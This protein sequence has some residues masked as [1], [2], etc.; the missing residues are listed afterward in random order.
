MVISYIYHCIEPIFV[1]LTIVYLV[2][3]FGTLSIWLSSKYILYN[4]AL[5]VTISDICC[6]IIILSKKLNIFIVTHASL[7]FFSCSFPV[8]SYSPLFL[9]KITIFSLAYYFV[10]KTLNR[11]F[12]YDLLVLVISLI[13]TS[14]MCAQAKMFCA[15]SVRFTNV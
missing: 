7:L 12:I 14:H 4:T 10:C 9:P 3:K 2:L 15:V 5:S 13:C 11:P 6:V 1:C 8:T